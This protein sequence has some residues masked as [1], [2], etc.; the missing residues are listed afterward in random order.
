[1]TVRVAHERRVP[2]CARN[3]G[4]VTVDRERGF[5]AALGMTTIKKYRYGPA[6]EINLLILKA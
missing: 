2:R 5:L 6:H 3:D 1:M 4:M